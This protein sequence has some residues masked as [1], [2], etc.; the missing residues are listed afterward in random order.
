MSKPLLVPTPDH[1]DGHALF[2]AADRL[3]ARL[4]ANLPEIMRELG[5]LPAPDCP[6]N[7]WADWLARKMPNVLAYLQVYAFIIGQ[8]LPPVPLRAVRLLDYGG[9]WGL[10]SLLAKEAGVGSVTYLDHNE[11]AARAAA[12]I[13]QAV[14]LPFDR[15]IV[16][17]ERALMGSF[18]AIVPSDVIEH[19]YSPERVFDAIAAV[20][21]PGAKVCH[22][23]GANPHSARMRRQIM[24]LRREEEPRLRALREAVIAGE[25]PSAA[26]RL[27]Q[28]TRGLDHAD[29]LASV[30]A[31]RATGAVPVPDHP[32]NTCDLHGYWYERLINPR[33]VAAKLARTG[34]EADVISCF[35]G[36]GR[37]RRPIRALKH[38]LSLASRLSRATGLSVVNHY[39]VADT[40]A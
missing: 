5:R 3:E 35:W 37:S 27:A 17:D 20:C 2:A 8:A 30:A 28:A 31:Y 15:A 32:T 33:E 22:Q 21:E 40:R 11:G 7:Y 6:P 1:V 29:I 14:G 25:L 24:R 26:A 16:G 23:T 19:V 39:A 34:F 4:V 13:A 36:P 9:G 10:M 18:N 38:V 12:T